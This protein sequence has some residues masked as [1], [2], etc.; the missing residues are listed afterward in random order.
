[1]VIRHLA[2]LLLLLLGAGT[3]I[4]TAPMLG[5]KPGDSAPHFDVSLLEGKTAS[6]PQPGR[7][8]LVFTYTSSNP[9]HTA[10]LEWSWSVEVGMQ[11]QPHTCTTDASWKPTKEV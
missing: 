7:P 6:F 4:A 5:L 3:C 2:S 10:M 8:L 11:A 1:M 9:F